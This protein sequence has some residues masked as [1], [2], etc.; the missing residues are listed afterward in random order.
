MMSLV[1]GFRLVVGDFHRTDA[2][3]IVQLF[4]HGIVIGIG[5]FGQIHDELGS[6][7]F[8]VG[9]IDIRHI[10]THDKQGT[11]YD[12]GGQQLNIVF[13]ETPDGVEL[14]LGGEGFAENIHRPHGGGDQVGVIF[15]HDQ[16]HG[17]LDRHDLHRRPDGTQ[18]NHQSEQ[19]NLQNGQGVEQESVAGEM[20]DQERDQCGDPYGRDKRDHGNDEQFPERRGE[21]HLEVRPEGQ[22][23]TVRELILI[24]PDIVQC[25]QQ[26]DRNRQQQQ[27]NEYERYPVGIDVILERQQGCGFNGETLPFR[28][29]GFQIRYV[30]LAEPFFTEIQVSGKPQVNVMGL[31]FC[32]IVQVFVMTDNFKNH[33]TLENSTFVIHQIQCLIL[34]Q[35]LQHHVIVELFRHMLIFQMVVVV[36]RHRHHPI[37]HLY[38]Q[39]GNEK[40][41]IL[42]EIEKYAFP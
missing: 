33:V 14:V 17:I 30:I 28:T 10:Q 37:Q 21:Q 40:A 35:I 2:F 27:R 19:G 39:N 8:Q 18:N 24:D 38:D 4:A 34:V 11:E 31:G 29:I 41:Q 13:P 22:I 1:T 3:H 5:R 25:H 12:S 15:R 6:G 42:A 36:G 23:H 26:E 20:I 7:V 9:G 16:G 32:Q